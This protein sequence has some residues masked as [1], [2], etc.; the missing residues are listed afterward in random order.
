M[1][2]T[3]SDTAT[4]TTNVEI[5]FHTATQPL[6]QM[7]LM[8]AL[9]E[10]TLKALER[11]AWQLRG[12]SSQTLTGMKWVENETT[13][14]FKAGI[15]LPGRL[16]RLALCGWMLTRIIG[17]YR[18]W[19]TR[20]AFIP[21][22]KQAD[23]LEQLHLKNAQL[24]VETSLKQGGAFLKIGQL[25]STRS[26]LLP[27]VWIETLSCLQ[28]QATPID[29]ERIEP[30]L[31]ERL[32]RPLAD[33]FAHIEMEP[34]AAASIGQVHKAT[35]LDGRIV[36]VKIRRPG[37]TQLVKTDLLLLKV[38]LDNVRSM[39]PDIDMD[40]VLSEIGRSL[41]EEL[42]YRREA[43]AMKRIGKHLT[44][45]SGVSCPHVI[46]ELCS[47]KLLVAEFVEGVKLNDALNQYQQ[48]GEQHKIDQLLTQVLDAWLLQILQLGHFHCDPHAGNLLVDDDNQLVLLD[49]GACQRLTETHRLGY[50]RVLQ[51][52]IVHE[53]ST[54]AHT[55]DQLGFKTRSG[56]PDTLLAFTKALLT[57]LSDRLAESV[58]GQP[59][60]PDSDE[61]FAQAQ[62]LYSSLEDD[63]VE[64]MPGDFIMLAR[65][66]LS[67]GGLFTHYRPN[68]DLASLMLKHLTWQQQA[69]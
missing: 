38:F 66:F 51:A 52:A 12:M 68:I 60:W 21:T 9:L 16:K 2:D 7:K 59:T 6:S 49:F 29:P 69:A 56:N 63:P 26:D 28:D 35:L 48:Q 24:F 42:D 23:A 13:N 25:L 64:Q 22:A 67:L 41:D 65:V 47:D 36:A 18:L 37:I 19:P 40:T 1:L 15:Q 62:T 14:L 17:S 4:N 20:S 43:S 33:V 31:V 58:N 61:L 44:K 50:L 45:I 39:L 5:E 30:L 3:T 10:S 53:D 11:S 32:N 27:A 46:D 54:I 34:I 55:L 57:Q 8:L